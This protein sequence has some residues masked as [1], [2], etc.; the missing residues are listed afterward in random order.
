M[1]S[2][3]THADTLRAL[4]KYAATG[5]RVL[6]FLQSKHPR[7]DRDTLLPVAKSLDAPDSEW[8]PPGHADFYASF[9]ASGLADSLAAEGKEVV[10]VSNV[11]NLGATVDLAILAHVV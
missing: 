9:V 4:P 8:Y 7:F 3:S 6:T 5:V 1:D 10:F 11:D 2:F